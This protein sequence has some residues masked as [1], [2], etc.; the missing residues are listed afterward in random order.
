ML[1]GINEK[2]THAIKRRSSLFIAR[3]YWI[4]IQC[5][6]III[7]IAFTMTF[8]ALSDYCC[9]LKFLVFMN[10]NLVEIHLVT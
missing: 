2:K 6:I 1:S 7:T 9:F 8:I 4:I 10:M 3:I 5:Q